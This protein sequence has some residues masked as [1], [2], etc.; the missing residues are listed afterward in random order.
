MMPVMGGKGRGH[1]A[2]TDPRYRRGRPVEPSNQ[3]S[4]DFEDEVIGSDAD[5]FGDIG[6]FDDGD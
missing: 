6:G 1:Y 2:E 3:G 5:T 4:F